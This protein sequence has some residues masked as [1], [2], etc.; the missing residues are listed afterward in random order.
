VVSVAESTTHSAL[1][2][3][4]PKFCFFCCV[5]EGAVLMYMIFLN[6]LNCYRIE[7]NLA[8]ASLQPGVSYSNF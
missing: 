1:S 6:I 8:I 3:K 7:Q 2:Q 4:G 5:N